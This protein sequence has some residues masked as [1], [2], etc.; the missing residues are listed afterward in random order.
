MNGAIESGFRVTDELKKAMKAIEQ[1][2]EVLGKE[3]SA[4]YGIGT[5]NIEAGVFTP[6]AS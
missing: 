5:V 2:E 6:Q 1:R 3:L 4:K